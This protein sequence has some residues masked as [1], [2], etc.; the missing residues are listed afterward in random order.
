[1]LAYTALEGQFD[2]NNTPLAPPGIKVIVHEKTQQHKTWG[3]HGVTGRYIISAMKKKPMLRM[4]HTQH[5]GVNTY[6]CGGIFPQHLIMPGLSAAEQAPKASK[7]LIHVI[8]NQGLKTLSLSEKANYRPSINWH[9]YLWPC[10]W[11]KHRIQCYLGKWQKMHL[12]GCQ[13]RSQGSTY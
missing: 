3:I 1:M 6:R 11:R 12:R 13:Y 8:K 2:F 9:K 5:Q 7:N 10:N 4:L